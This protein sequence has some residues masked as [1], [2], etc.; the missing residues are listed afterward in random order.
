MI[1]V[2][3]AYSTLKKRLPNNFRIV[4]GFEIKDAYIFSVI[5]KN[6]KGNGGYPFFSVLKRDGTIGGY[7]P[8]QDIPEY[9][10]AIKNHEIDIAYLEKPV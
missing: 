10:N 1:S 9:M 4:D 2:S 8:M 7:N 5:D 6:G 3:S